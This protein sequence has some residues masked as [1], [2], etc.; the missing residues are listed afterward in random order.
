MLLFTV[1]APKLFV[2]QGQWVNQ[3]DQIAAVGSTGRSTG[4]HLHYH[5]Y[6]TWKTFKSF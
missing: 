5:S 6:K 4:S 1:I 3:G 2:K